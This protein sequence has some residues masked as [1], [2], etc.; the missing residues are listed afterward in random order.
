MSRKSNAKPT[1]VHLPDCLDEEIL[2]EI[3]ESG[4]SSFSHTTAFIRKGEC[5]YLGRGR[6]ARCVSCSPRYSNGLLF[7]YRFELMPSVE[8]L[9]QFGKGDPE[10]LI[11]KRKD[12]EKVRS[13]AKGLDRFDELRHLVPELLDYADSLDRCSI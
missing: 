1:L 9:E 3:L 10:S 8:S 6:Y 12:A 4:E 11:K 5:F 2:L 13:L 7:Y